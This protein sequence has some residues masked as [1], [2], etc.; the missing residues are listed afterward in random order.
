MKNS[1]Y[2][3]PAVMVLTVCTLILG[4]CQ[5]AI[6]PYKPT[7]TL[8]K[9]QSLGPADTSTPAPTPT[10]ISKPSPTPTA[11]VGITAENGLQYFELTTGTGEVPTNG[12]V[13]IMNYRAWLKDGTEVLNSTTGGTPR[14][15][16][17]GQNL[18][19]PGWEQGLRMMKAGGKALMVLPPEL[20]FGSEAKGNIPANST[21][22]L[23]VELVKVM[24]VPI[25]QSVAMDQYKKLESGLMFYDLQVGSGKVAL[26]TTFVKTAYTIW[27][28][29]GE[30][31][32]YIASSE[33]ES[34]I[35]FQVGKSASVIVG[36][37]EG[38]VGMKV[39]GKRQLIIPPDLAYGE[40]GSV[41]VPPNATLM[42]EI[43]LIEVNE[44][45]KQTVIDEFN[46]TT[47]T[48]GLRIYEIT[49][50]TGPTPQKGQTVV[51]Q[52]VA[53]Y[54]D[55]TQFDS[56]YFRGQPYEFKLGLG[57][58]IKGWDEG[59]ATMKVGGKR[60]LVI[61]PE[62]GYGAAGAGNAIPG[63]TTLVYEIELLEI[64]P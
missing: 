41:T 63:D 17:M 49:I 62:L 6:N 15:A 37:N 39:G 12:D 59:I 31:Y 45:V 61:P 7:S 13:V 4:A 53:W 38:V 24:P 28:V 20:A 16:A 35:F 47:T 32:Q 9:T 46:Y 30:N 2:A 23:D 44:P 19:L 26:K 27:V 64:R 1:S 57:E 54:V 11:L 3:H 25:P 36:L 18:L 58:V 52:Y 51:V 14:S 42:M 33:G 43:E 8:D 5:S 56:S 40:A 29:D 21:I 55:G 22:Y 50:G 48:S 10:I 34:L 60:K